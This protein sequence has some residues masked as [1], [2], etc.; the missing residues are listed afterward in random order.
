MRVGAHAG[1]DRIVFEFASRGFGFRDVPTYEI[2]RA[3]APYGQ[4]GTGFPLAVA[5]DPVLRIRLIGASSLRADYSEAYTGRRDFV[6]GFPVL[7]QLRDGGDYESQNS[8]YAG[9]SGAACL[10]VR[11]LSDPSRLVIDLRRQ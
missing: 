6:P 1:Y 9:V 11:A 8:W 10:Q 7:R 3:T 4:E 2:T 5:G